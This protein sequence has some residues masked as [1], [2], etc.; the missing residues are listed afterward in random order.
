MFAHHIKCS[1]E[2][3]SRYV[4]LVNRAACRFPHMHVHCTLLRAAVQRLHT[5]FNVDAISTF[6]II[7]GTSNIPGF[8]ISSSPARTVMFF[9]VS[10]TFN[11]LSTNC[12][13]LMACSTFSLSMCASIGTTKMKVI[14]ASIYSR[15]LISDMLRI[16][17]ATTVACV[18]RM[19][20]VCKV[21]C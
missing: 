10:D 3:F 13:N 17:S 5:N 2:P 19:M 15:R 20:G 14:S 1:A 8:L 7:S 9:G 11:G 18:H 16:L 4:V 21:F 6:P 12:T